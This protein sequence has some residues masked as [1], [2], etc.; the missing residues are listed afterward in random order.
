MKLLLWVGAL[1]ALYN[2]IFE[3]LF[4]TSFLCWSTYIQYNNILYSLFLIFNT[5]LL[6]PRS[7]CS[8]ALG[9]TLKWLS[10]VNFILKTYILYRN[11]ILD[12]VFTIPWSSIL[13]N[14]SQLSM[15]HV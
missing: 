11:R 3:P 1:G 8:V 10:P 14:W 9:R 6:N 12:V 4:I 2:I 15:A 13:F 7:I 5:P